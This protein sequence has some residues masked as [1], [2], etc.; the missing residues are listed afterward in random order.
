MDE[1]QREFFNINKQLL[2]NLRDLYKS[3]DWKI[4]AVEF[5]EEYL[6]SVMG[7]ISDLQ[8]LYVDGVIVDE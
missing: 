8:C 5:Y 7:E 2:S 3:K 4:G 1:L 6:E